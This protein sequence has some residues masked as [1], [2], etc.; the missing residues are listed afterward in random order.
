MQDY[1]RKKMLPIESESKKKIDHHKNKIN[2]IIN[3]LYQEISESAL[4]LDKYKLP[5]HGIPFPEKEN[6][7]NLF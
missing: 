1:F 3:E 2:G 5:L 7:I 4:N 6:P